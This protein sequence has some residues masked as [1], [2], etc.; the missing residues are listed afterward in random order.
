MLLAEWDDYM[1]VVD[2]ERHD[3]WVY[4]VSRPQTK[5]ERVAWELECELHRT[6]VRLSE[7]DLAKMAR[8]EIGLDGVSPGLKRT[9][10]EWSYLTPRLVRAEWKDKL[11]EREARRNRST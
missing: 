1:C 9:L 5:H 10:G 4:S 8:R 11:A 7:G 3:E 2:D 6:L